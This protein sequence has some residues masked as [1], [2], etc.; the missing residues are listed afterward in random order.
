MR[1]GDS[2]IPECSP[3]SAS[4]ESAPKPAR[5]VNPY[6]TGGGGVTFERKVA[7]QYL[8]RLLAGEGASELGE[9]RHVV[10][11]AFQ[12]APAHPVDDLVI[13]ASRPDEFGPSLML[14]L[15]VRRSPNLVSSDESAQAL[16]QKYVRAMVNQPT[17]SMERRCGLVVSGPQSHTEQVQEL[18]ELAAVQ[19]DAPG[20]FDLVQT[21]GRF[22]RD[23]R[24]RL[25]HIERLVERALK[26]LGTAEPDTE[27]IQERTWHLLS[28]LAVRMPRLESPD[29][30]DWAGVE[31]SLVSVA[32][33]QDLAG[34]SRLR[35]RLVWLAGEYHAK[36]ARIDLS[37]LRR[38]SHDRLDPDVRRHRQAWQSLYHLH[39]VAIKSVRDEIV[40][41]DGDRR[42]RIDRSDAA[43]ELSEA[44][45]DTGAVLVSGD[46]G[47]GKSALT[48]LSLNAACVADPETRQGLCINLRQIP[49]LTVDFEN[50]LG[51]PLSTLLSELSAPTRMLVI[52]GADAVTEGMEDA[53]RYLVDAA[54]ECGVKIVAVASTD[55]VQVVR[56]VLTDRFADGI[57]EYAIKPLDD[58]ELDEIVATFSELR[59]LSSNPRS[60]DLLRRL[61]V[62]DLLVR[63]RPTGTPLND[64]DALREVWS[65]IVR[66]RGRSDRGHPNDREVV[67][68]Q[69]ADC[70]LTGGDRLEA[71]SGLDGAAISGLRHDGLL[72]EST[73]N[74]FMVGPDF[75]H[76]EV[77]RYAIA[78]L[79]LSEKDPTSK[80]VSA[81]APRWALGAVRLACQALLGEPDRTTTPLTGRFG[82]LQESFDALVEA[83]HGSRWGDLPSEA[84]V[85]LADPRMVLRDAWPT[86][87]A[88]DAG[89]LRRLA[90]VVDQRLRND[91]RT[92]DPATIEPMI[93]L[94]LEEETPWQSGEYVCDLLREWL[95]GHVFYDTPSDHPLRIQL[96]EHLVGAY[97]EGE[98]R[99]AEQRE[100]AAAA[101][102]SRTQEEIDRVRQLQESHPELFTEIGSGGRIRRHR[103]EVP[104]ECRDR[105]FLELLAL[106]GPDLGEDGARILLRV[107]RDAPWLLAPTVEEPFT[108]Y[109][110][111]QFGRGLLAHLTEAYYIDEEA[112]GSNSFD[113]G[114]RRHRARR[115][116]IFSPLAGRDR[117][118]FMALF[119]TDF[120]GGVATLNR[121]LNH[122]ALIR[123]RTLARLDSMGQGL[124]GLDIG[125]YQAY[126]EITGTR[127]LYV[128]DQ[129]VWRMYRG[130]G[131][132][133]YP[134]ISALQAL[135]S[136]CDQL[137]EAGVPPR[138]LV[139]MLLEGCENLAMVG[140]IVGILVRHLEEAGDLLDPY[141]TEPL[142]WRHE[143]SR[144][145]HESSMLA[146]NPEEVKAPER[147]GWSLKETAMSM[148]LMA[149]QDRAS[150]LRALGETLVERERRA[151]EH[152][153]DVPILDDGAD[154]QA[155]I[156]SQVAMVR[157][158]ASNLDRSSY[159]VQRTSEGLQIL[160]TPPEGVVQSQLRNRADLN[161]TSEEI[162]LKARYYTNPRE[163]SVGASEL[164]A[165]LASARDLLENPP[166]LGNQRPWDVPTLVAATAIEAYMLRQIDISDDDL[167]F[168]IET[169]LQVFEGEIPDRPY[170]Y[171]ETYYEEGADRS[172]ARV[173]PLL[174]VPEATR[175]RDIAGSGNGEVTFERVS[176]AGL[177]AAHTIAS[178]TRLNLA[179]GLDH[180]WA[181]PCVLE[182]PCRHLVGWHIVTETVRY[183]AISGW[184]P[185]TG[186]LIITALGEPLIESL[187]NTPDDS[188]IPTRLDASIRALAPAAIA[189]ICVS[190]SAQDLL[191][192]ILE[193]QR[194]SLLTDEDKVMDDRG[195]HTLVSARALLTLAQDGGDIAVHQHIDAYADSPAL[196]GNLL[197]TLCAA[198]EEDPC[199]AETAGRIWPRVI[200]HVLDLNDEGHVPFHGGFFGD[201]ALASLIPNT[202]SPSA[203]L[204]REI[205]DDP[206]VWWEPFSLRPDIER[207]LATD[208]SK[209]ECV[210]RLIAFLG[211]LGPQEQVRVG[212]P[213][214]TGLVLESPGEIAAGSFLLPAW[215]ITMRSPAES[216]SLSEQWQQVVDALVVEGVTRL[217]PYSE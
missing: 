135:E 87:R 68:L 156:E 112:D 161:R 17:D 65:R 74:P 51:L 134:C 147:R 69:L 214:L 124:E 4:D 100:A 29:E 181:T 2:Q 95:H 61:V 11:V 33:G 193:A 97:A 128:G 25:G 131:V 159:Q 50:T 71:I 111:G 76:D 191:T 187:K 72:Q 12:Q 180:L 163:A 142:I 149:D 205:K 38:D 86:L 24:N 201:L 34:A 179:R 27:L 114:I 162:R 89:G 188:I 7:V 215:L 99:L 41:V 36:S 127:R 122:A 129:H 141:I 30:T 175:L 116:S 59:S 48:L 40:S 77:R 217:A 144:V 140:L 133:P 155:N 26:D 195:T 10:S 78:R 105:V 93:E 136:A 47:V 44:A 146:A 18:A 39:D 119:S 19:I 103:P 37:L 169:L 15:E 43:T 138:S 198:A 16:I 212:L 66:R 13:Y 31:N 98:R 194:R 165:D 35:D 88:D 121:M 192:V 23:V 8:A 209:V 202:A 55:S 53:F 207:L 118:P 92:I 9:G 137:I 79:L 153:Q 154:G 208:A 143:F 213:W 148:A 174:L 85:T 1:D 190:S 62:V 196:L 90:R 176:A 182:N 58:I 104:S 94:L 109:A 67:L 63:G 203:Y 82:T 177:E 157:G 42:V 173:L 21:P 139:M 204:Y 64:A 189:D 150:V 6:A 60:R 80:L 158:W 183:C 28:R 210:D 110:L 91:N 45:E 206:I 32:Q 178:E 14:A 197:R 167:A 20:F 166:S 132:S 5:G 106:L 22:N 126:L 120:R 102:S 123:A 200:R 171:E 107:A 117:G 160:H 54:S 186:G 172:A 83:G 125:P 115:D 3:V 49:K 152:G 96:R 184:N 199:R 211:G 185:D 216:V 145:V 46:S 170:E 130:T 56:D 108:G 57:A 75:A 81:G 168:S 52:D 164:K 84:L 70:A 151:I 73:D 101:S 113:K